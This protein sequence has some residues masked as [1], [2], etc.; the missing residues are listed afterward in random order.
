MFTLNKCRL[1]KYVGKP[2]ETEL[3]NISGFQT[4]QSGVLRLFILVAR[5]IYSFISVYVPF[6]N[7]RLM[8][9]LQCSM[10][11]FFIYYC[12]LESLKNN[13]GSFYMKTYLPSPICLIST[14]L[15]CL[16]M[17]PV[18]DYNVVSR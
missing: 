11:S 15:A 8:L 16:I 10:F 13:L 6:I 5:L 3:L 2:S 18:G 4:F 1:E 12:L 17:S 9:R 14:V 7:P